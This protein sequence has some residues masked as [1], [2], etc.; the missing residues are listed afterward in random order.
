[1][2]ES[3]N[4][5]FVGIKITKALQEDIDSPAPGV[6]HYFES[7][8]KEYLQIVQMRDEKFIGRYINDGFPVANLADVGRNV[9]SIV[10]LITKGKRIEEKEVQIYSC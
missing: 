8:N 1:M 5:L 3:G 7:N 6:K 4:R 10:K 9:C 2:E